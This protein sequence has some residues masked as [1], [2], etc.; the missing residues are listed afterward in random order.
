MIP[1]IYETSLASA[2]LVTKKRQVFDGHLL[3]HQLMKYDLA[4]AIDVLM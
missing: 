3:S 2:M 1:A 4:Q